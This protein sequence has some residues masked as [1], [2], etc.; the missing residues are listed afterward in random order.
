MSLKSS[1]PRF[2]VSMY[3]LAKALIEDLYRWHKGDVVA[4]KAALRRI[5]EH[6][7]RLDEAE[8]ELDKRVDAIEDADVSD[9]KVKA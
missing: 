2:L 7:L 8:A 6:G 1:W 5:R 3:P 9:P 4:A